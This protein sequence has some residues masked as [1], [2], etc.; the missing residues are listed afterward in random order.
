MAQQDSLQIKVFYTW[1]QSQQGEKYDPGFDRKIEWDIPLL[2]GYDYEFVENISKD[3]G[4]HHYKGI[5][6]PGLIEKISSW[7]PDALLIFSWSFKS[8]LAC[9]RYFKNKIPI[10]FRGDSN[11][12]DEQPGL[13]RFARR[14]FLKWVYRHVDYAF[15]V[16]TNN[17]KYFLAHGLKESQLYFAPHAVDNERFWQNAQINEEQAQEWRTSLGIGEN[18]FLLLFAGKLEQKKNPGYLLQLVKAIPEKNIKFLIVGNGP[19]ENA[20]KAS[21]LNEKRIVF[22]DFQNQLKMPVVYRM[23]NAFILPSKGPGETWGLAVNEAMA[24]SRPVIVSKKAGCAVDLVEREKNGI[25]IDPDE[26]TTCIEYLF[27]LKNDNEKMIIAGNESKRIVSG[28][29]FATIVR[30]I[31]DFLQFE[32]NKSNF[33]NQPVKA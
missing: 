12:I 13:R 14:I 24:C 25:I 33:K 20:L 19:L 27:S 3:P 10:L 17:K 15:Y 1:S 26:L 18:D 6:N 21:A 8:H 28:F 7:K 32:L 4:T 9:M 2:D 22:I 23:A 5:D 30:N 11:L 31:C 16:G 29:S